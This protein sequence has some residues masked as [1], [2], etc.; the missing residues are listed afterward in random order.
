MRNDQ[1]NS[2]NGAALDRRRVLLGG[3][4]LA[5]ASVIATG[6]SVE[7]AQ[8]QTQAPA[9]QTTASPGGRP[10]ILVNHGR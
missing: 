4:T 10:N 1:V 5:A 3:T 8:G 2:D 6:T 7:V 9:R